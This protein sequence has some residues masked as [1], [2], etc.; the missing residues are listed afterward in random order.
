MST[1]TSHFF[2][3][4]PLNINL[5][6]YA[7]YN[8][9][10]TFSVLILICGLLSLYRYKNRGLYQHAFYACSI[11]GALLVFISSVLFYSTSKKAP[12]SVPSQIMLYTYGYGTIFLDL[13]FSF[14]VIG[15]KCIHRQLALK[16]KRFEYYWLF[17]NLTEIIIFTILL[18]TQT[19][20]YTKSRLGWFT[21]L[22][23]TCGIFNCIFYWVLCFTKF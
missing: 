20:L 3:L 17:F 18:V 2:E 14:L 19:K 13:G 10:L 15:L 1:N 22:V 12:W 23:A 5:V 16:S 11:F 4:Y 7:N 8:N 21:I 6:Q 9:D